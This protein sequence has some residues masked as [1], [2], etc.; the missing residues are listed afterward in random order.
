MS[1]LSKRHCA[2]SSA[3]MHGTTSCSTG[4]CLKQS[5]S[6]K[7]K[8]WL[9]HAW[10]CMFTHI[11]FSECCAQIRVHFSPFWP[12]SSRSPALHRPRA[13]RGVFPKRPRRDD[14]GLAVS[15]IDAVV[16]RLVVAGE[17]SQGTRRA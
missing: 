14:S 10:M 13:F 8:V 3:P 16:A 11:V 2:S 1:L 9:S 5:Y 17:R 6:S 15:R 12:R 7:S 4:S